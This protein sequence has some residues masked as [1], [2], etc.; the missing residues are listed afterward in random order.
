MYAIADMM[1][2]A[3]IGDDM[4]RTAAD[5]G[6]LVRENRIARGMT[7]GDLA[8]RCGTGRQFVVEL[9]GGKA[10]V[11]LE[12]ALTVAVEV[13]LDLVDFRRCAVVSSPAQDDDLLDEMPRF[14]PGA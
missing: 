6:A 1:A 4:I 12:K 13:G 11:Q 5:F 3:Y 2:I 7:Q 9:E 8:E 14:G 10:T